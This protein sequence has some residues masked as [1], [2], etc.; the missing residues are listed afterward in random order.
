MDPS[1]NTQSN[2][3]QKPPSL[4]ST[5]SSVTLAVKPDHEKEKELV[6]ERYTYVKKTG[7]ANPDA[8]PKEKSKLGKFLTKFQSPAVKKTNAARE[9]EL[10]EEERTGTKKYTV[11][12][13]PG[14]TNQSTAAFM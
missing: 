2:P 4:R 5:T 14:S 1:T 6:P 11:L 3:N 12:G 8:Q 13:T 9:K 7:P 10:L